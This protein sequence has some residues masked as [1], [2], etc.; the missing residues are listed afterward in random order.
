MYTLTDIR[1]AYWNY[2]HLL[3]YLQKQNRTL[4]KVRST[5]VS[6]EQQGT[7]RLEGKAGMSRFKI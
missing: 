2:L 1:T 3:Q 4:H 7:V 5:K 6:T